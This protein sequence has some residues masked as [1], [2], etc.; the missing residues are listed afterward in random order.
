MN[1]IKAIIEQAFQRH[2]EI[3]PRTAQTHVKDAVYEAIE[4]L[5]SGKARVAENKNGKWIVN[6]WLNKAV[7]LYFRIEDSNFVKGGYT[8]YFD[9]VPSKF[10]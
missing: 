1:D 7:L 2:A 6:E 4:L 10:A 8:N 5:D 3:T 9:K